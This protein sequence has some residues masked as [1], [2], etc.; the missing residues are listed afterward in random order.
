[1][2]RIA[3]V[4]LP[5]T[6]RME[7]ALTY[8]YGIGRSAARKVLRE[9]GVDFDVKTDDLPEEDLVKLR[10][11]DRRPESRGR[12][13]ARGGAQ[14]QALRR[15]RRV[16]RS[17]PPEE[18]TGA[19]PAHAHQRAHS[20]G[21][22]QDDRRQETGADEVSAA[23]GRHGKTRKYE[24][25]SNRPG[26]SADPAQEGEARRARGHRAHP[27]DVQQHDRHDHR[28]DRQRRRLGERR[29]RRL[30]GLA[31]RHAAS[32]PQLA[33]EAAA[34]RAI[35]VGM[36]TVQV[37]VKGP[38]AGRE[39]ALRSLQ[40]RGILDHSHQRRDAD[41]AQRLPPAEKAARVTAATVVKGRTVRPRRF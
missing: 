20:Q 37:F 13:A 16:S 2:A 29:Q 10:R 36:R 34:K 28:P 41:P 4:D 19:R 23:R 39:S 7:I 22:A 35:D 1:M 8:I 14:H 17:A 38:G 27:L 6:K 33:A 15:S 30:Q 18:P 31:Q 40:C 21:S 32:R 9:A 3:G 24:N 5:K 12:S 26:A 11:G 25:C